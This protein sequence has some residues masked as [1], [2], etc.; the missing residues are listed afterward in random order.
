[1][2]QHAMSV[3]N[4][5]AAVVRAGFNSALLALVTQSSGTAA[6]STT[7][8]GQVWWDTTNNLVKV[9]NGTNTAWINSASFDGT[10]WI[11]YAGG[12]PVLTGPALT[13]IDSLTLAQQSSAPTTGAN[14]ITV[15]NDGGRP[16]VR[17][18]SNGLILPLTDNVQIARTATQVITSGTDVDTGLQVTITPRYSGRILLFATTVARLVN[19]AGNICNS[20][21]FL[22]DVTPA[23]NIEDATAQVQIGGATSVSWIGNVQVF[24]ERSAVPLG[25]AREYRLRMSMLSGTDI[26]AQSGSQA[27]MMFAAELKE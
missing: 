2:P 21:W 1:M 10:T 13:G 18:A 7:H 22:Y 25:V 17:L 5:E 24:T 8:A 27:G 20:L 6:P 23:T 14:E 16:V 19:S 26:R 12:L 3:P 9:R 11:P 4:A 15:F